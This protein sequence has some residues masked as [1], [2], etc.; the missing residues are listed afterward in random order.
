MSE[1]SDRR[2]FVRHADIIYKLVL[3][4]LVGLWAAFPPHASQPSAANPRV[5][6]A[7]DGQT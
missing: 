2:W 3:V 6:V 7:T 5:T 4:A 1:S